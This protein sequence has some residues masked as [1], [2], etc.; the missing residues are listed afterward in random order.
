MRGDKTGRKNFPRGAPKPPFGEAMRGINPCNFTIWEER[1][2]NHRSTLFFLFVSIALILAACSPKIRGTV[3]LVDPDMQPVVGES[4][5]GT[6]VN[7]INT[8]A[9]VEKASYSVIAD[10]D[11]KFESEKKAIT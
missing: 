5:N 9:K 11:G 7:M 2:M 8:T 6:V 3:K 1:A 4:P 10:E